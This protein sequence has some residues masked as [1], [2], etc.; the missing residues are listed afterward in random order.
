MRVTEIEKIVLEANDDGVVSCKRLDRRHRRIN[1]LIHRGVGP[2]VDADR[3]Q[4]NVELVDQLR[5]QDQNLLVE[6]IP[7]FGALADLT[8]KGF[9]MDENR[10]ESRVLRWVGLGRGTV[11]VHRQLLSGPAV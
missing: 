6:N 4:E 9:V 5:P 1:D 10:L 8:G 3:L 2:L 11:V 7:G